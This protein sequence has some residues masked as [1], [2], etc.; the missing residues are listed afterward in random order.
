MAIGDI[1]K[2]TDKQRI[3]GQI[4]EN[5]HHFR[6]TAI[7]TDPMLDLATT[8]RDNVLPVWRNLQAADL[9][10]FKLEVRG[11]TD[12]NI[13]F[14]LDVSVFG[15]QSGQEAIALQVAP[16]ITWR[17]GFIGRSFRGR[18]YVAGTTEANSAGGVLTPTMVTA[19]QAAADEIISLPAIGGLGEGYHLVVYS[20]TLTTATDVTGYT[21]QPVVGTQRRRRQGVGT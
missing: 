19:L 5:V 7:S 16:I 2:L 21:V 20:Q 15:S 11:V 3:F 12:P 17:T 1:F 8:F 6:Q 18:T 13:G 4:V 14:D 10:H 9:E